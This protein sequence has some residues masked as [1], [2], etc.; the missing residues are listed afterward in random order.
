MN[1]HV[2]LKKKKIVKDFLDAILEFPFVKKKKQRLAT[3]KKG[4]DCNYKHDT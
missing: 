2:K 3:S 1:I 4:H